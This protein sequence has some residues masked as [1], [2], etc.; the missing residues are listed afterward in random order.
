MKILKANEEIAKFS[1]TNHHSEAAA[2][3]EILN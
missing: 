2:I 3:N 1:K